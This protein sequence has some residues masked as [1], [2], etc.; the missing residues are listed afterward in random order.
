MPGAGPFDGQGNYDTNNWY[1]GNRVMV[2]GTN[3]IVGYNGEGWRGSGQANQYMQYNSD[4]LFIGQF[5][6]PS[7]FGTTAL[8]YGAA[9]NSFSPFLVNVNGT[10]YLYNNDE[11]DRSLQRWQVTGLS[12]VQE[13]SLGVLLGVAPSPITSWVTTPITVPNGGFETDA[14]GSGTWGSP[15]HAAPTNWTISWAGG[16]YKYPGY[17]IEAPGVYDATVLS[18]PAAVEGTKYA[19]IYPGGTWGSGPGSVGTGVI[20]ATTTGITAK[21]VGGSVYTATVAVGEP[22]TDSNTISAHCPIFTVS[23]LDAGVVVATGTAVG[24]DV[25]AG[26]WRDASVSWIAPVGST[27]DSLQIQVAMTGFTNINGQYST[28]QAMV[29][30]VRLAMTTPATLTTTLAFQAGSGVGTLRRNHEP[31]GHF[32]GWL[33]GRAQ[34]NGRVQHQWRERGQR[35]HQRQR[36]GNAKRREPGG[37]PSRHLHGLCDGQLRRR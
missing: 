15:P 18:N 16:S 1:G 22:L 28:T 31:Y 19:R 8:A 21:V 17:Q 10:L 11:S 3:V 30:N 27:G 9:G 13:T 2:N 12:T 20:T 29:D 33:R 35:H 37:F 4:G 25:N 6:T 23:I 5:G 7:G 32:D 26:T 34:R 36:S 14:G 24:G